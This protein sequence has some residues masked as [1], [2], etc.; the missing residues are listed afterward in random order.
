[1]GDRK[2]DMVFADPPYNAVIE[3]NVSGKGKVKYG[4]FAM[5]CGEINEVQ[6][7]Q[8][9]K[10]S[11]EVLSRFSTDGSPINVPRFMRCGTAQRRLQRRCGRCGA[12][13]ESVF[14]W[15]CDVNDRK[16]GRGLVHS[17]ATYEF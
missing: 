1:M 16:L 15:L 17:M 7:T 10:E 12:W 2:A 13:R 3:D 14:R 8:F 4:D 11:F 9:L 5:A 6:F